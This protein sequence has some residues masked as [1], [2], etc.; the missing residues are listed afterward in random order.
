MKRNLIRH[1][2]GAVMVVLVAGTMLVGCD[3]KQAGDASMKFV[4]V[5]K[6]L[7]DSGLL[8]QEQ[9]HLKAVNQSLQNGQH[10]AEKSYANLPANK[11]DTARNA[12]RN[13]LAQQWKGQQQAAR[14]VVMA[15]LKNATDS[16]RTENK[17]GVILPTQVAM[18]V[19]PE[20]DVS[21]ELTEKLKT[22]KLEF[23]K[24]PDIT[25]KAIQAEK[26]AAK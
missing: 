13:I 16:Y 26:P 22:A 18:S 8:K 20:L 6:V 17:I 10:L 19:A 24:V 4:N 14:N 9:D 23:A 25:V 7:V 1:M 15:A 2:A 5:E 3:G 21:A 11:V 12:D